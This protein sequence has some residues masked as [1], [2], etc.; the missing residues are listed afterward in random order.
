MCF[1][2]VNDLYL[3]L[4]EETYIN[5]FFFLELQQSFAFRYRVFHLT[6][7]LPAGLNYKLK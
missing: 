7:S 6:D 4:S 1:L 5:E 3:Y 2:K